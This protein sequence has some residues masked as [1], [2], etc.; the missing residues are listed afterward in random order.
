[1]EEERS[2]DM[3][4]CRST[5]ILSFSFEPGGLVSAAG[6]AD[7]KRFMNQFEDPR[8]MRVW[9]VS[10]VWFCTSSFESMSK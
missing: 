2:A 6:I 10:I 8:D 5:W 9:V 4:V 1:V 7:R 3:R